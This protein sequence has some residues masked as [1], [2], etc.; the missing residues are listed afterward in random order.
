MWGVV[1]QAVSEL[2]L[3]FVGY[4]DEHFRRLARDCRSGLSGFVLGLDPRELLLGA[5]PDRAGACQVG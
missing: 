2:D 3:D 1:Q 5:L 4:A